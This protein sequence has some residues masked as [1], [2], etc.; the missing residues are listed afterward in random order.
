M[1]LSNTPGFFLLLLEYY[2]PLQGGI[3]FSP[4]N[5]DMAH[6]LGYNLVVFL[7]P[8]VPASRLS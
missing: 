7:D 3:L 1:N 5:L 8:L 4:P 2:L 6:R